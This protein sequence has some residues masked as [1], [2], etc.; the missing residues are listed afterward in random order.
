MANL[1]DR[2][3]GYARGEQH[4]WHLHPD[5]HP[6]ERMFTSP[7]AP[8]LLSDA[9]IRRLGL[10]MVDNA[11][12]TDSGLSP[13]PSR[14]F[15]HAGIATAVPRYF[16]SSSFR[17]EWIDRRSRLIKSWTA[18]VLLLQ[19]AEDTL[20]PKRVLHRRGMVL[21]RLPESAARC[22]CSTAGTSG[23]SRRRLRPSAYS[24]SFSAK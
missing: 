24:N 1:G 15:S 21:A 16:H 10:H 8:A 20:Q 5:L 11:A 17:Q 3:T 4:L 2:V 18:P 12:V 6:Q 14:E 9:R 22:T 19:G 13:V 23:P 7:E